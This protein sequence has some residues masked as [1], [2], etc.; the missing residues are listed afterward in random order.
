MAAIRRAAT[1]EGRYAVVLSMPDAPEGALERP[2]YAFPV[3]GSMRALKAARGIPQASSTAASSW[4]DAA[5]VRV[6]SRIVLLLTDWA[7][8]QVIA[9]LAISGN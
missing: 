2:A 8:G 9:G 1:P 4:C 5:W 6:L 3:L 7:P